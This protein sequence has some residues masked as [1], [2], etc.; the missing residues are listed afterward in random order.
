MVGGPD[1]FRCQ[2]PGRSHENHVRMIVLHQPLQLAVTDR[3]GV[4]PGAG[5]HGSGFAPRLP[6]HR[7]NRFVQR[8]A[9]PNVL[10]GFTSFGVVIASGTVRP[11]THDTTG[12]NPLV[13]QRCYH[14]K[15]SDTEGPGGPGDIVQVEIRD[16]RSNGRAVFID[17]RIMNQ[18]DVQI[19]ASEP[20]PASATTAAEF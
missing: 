15:R 10:Q 11:V 19:D 12:Q 8:G 7:L 13:F 2:A 14:L 3:P 20:F 1:D 16:G 4:M 6:T 18:S 5:R 9:D 17:D